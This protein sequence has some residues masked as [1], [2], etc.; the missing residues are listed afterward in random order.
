MG[1]WLCLQEPCSLAER[2]D[3]GWVVGGGPSQRRWGHGQTSKDGGVSAGEN[4]V[5]P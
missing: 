5:V 4:E 3:I 1:Y 2:E